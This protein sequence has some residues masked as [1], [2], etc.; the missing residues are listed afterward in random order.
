MPIAH[1]NSDIR[2]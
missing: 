1:A 2:T